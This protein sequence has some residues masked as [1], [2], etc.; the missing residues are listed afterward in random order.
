MPANVKAEV[1]LVLIG[2]YGASPV[3]P[4]TPAG[5]WTLAGSKVATAMESYVW[6]RKAT[7]ADEVGG[8]VTIPIGSAMKSTLTLAAYRGAATTGAIAAIASNTDGGTCS[9]RPAPSMP[10]P[11]A[12]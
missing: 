6:T 4:T 8:S 10:R 11:G 5:G 1:Q 2:S 7:S 9:T 12:G 3:N